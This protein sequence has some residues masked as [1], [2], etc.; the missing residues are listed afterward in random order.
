[1]AAQD[2][3]ARLDASLERAGTDIKIFR[4]A[5]FVECRARVR[6]LSAQ[7]LRPGSTGGQGTFRA[8]LSPTKFTV[9]GAAV[10]LPIKITDKVLWN[11]SQRSITYVWPVIMDG[12]VVR[13]EAD[14][15][16]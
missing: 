2:T 15:M 6:G 1:M 13:I 11:G 16:G 4:A 7:E 8:I 9:A 14:F 10:S 12:Q 5:S 3:I